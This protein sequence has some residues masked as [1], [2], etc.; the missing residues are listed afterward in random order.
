MIEG[1][2]DAL[3][4]YG[5]RTAML[6]YPDWTYFSFGQYRILEKANLARRSLDERVGQASEETP[7]PVR[8]AEA[9]RLPLFE[10]ADVAIWRATIIEETGRLLAVYLEHES[11]LRDLYATLKASQTA[12]YGFAEF[13]CWYDHLAYSHTVDLLEDAGLILIPGDSFAAALWLGNASGGH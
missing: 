13:F 2:F 12:P 11:T 6:P 1:D 9:F 4:K 8:L 10:A 5:Q 3:G 7:S